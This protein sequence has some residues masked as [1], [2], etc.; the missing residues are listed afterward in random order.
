MDS[1]DADNV[2]PSWSHDGQWTYF[3]SNHGGNGFHV[4]KVKATGKGKPLQLTKGEGFKALESEDGR[5]VYYTRLADPRIRRVPRD[6]GQETMVEGNPTPDLWANWT[7]A[8][9][10]I[11]FLTSNVG[12]PYRLRRFDVVREERPPWFNLDRPSF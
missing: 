3:A 5:F 9:Q 10:S 12:K 2:V 1:Q 11:F 8:N 7:I 6:G 4:W